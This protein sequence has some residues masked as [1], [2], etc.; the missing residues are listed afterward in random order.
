MF[1][2]PRQRRAFTLIE[3]LV[4][5]TVIAILVALL[6]P[7]VQQ[8]RESSRRASC[9]NNLR[10]LGLAVHMFHD[11]FNQIPPGAISEHKMT[12]AWL[13]LPYIEQSAL[14][15]EWNEGENFYLQNAAVRTTVVQTHL[16]PSR[17]RSSA[18]SVCTSDRQFYYSGLGGVN[19]KIDAAEGDYAG[20]CG[21]RYIGGGMG[22][23]DQEAYS[24]WD[25]MFPQARGWPG[26]PGRPWVI[27]GWKSAVKMRDVVDGLSNTIMLGEIDGKNHPG[28][29]YIRNGDHGFGAFLGTTAPLNLHGFGSDHKGVVHFAFADGRVHPISTN[30]DLTLAGHLATRAGGEVIGEY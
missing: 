22:L 17:P 10:Q 27:K 19:I 21:E 11:T 4:V 8:V 29:L 2:G 30:I 20:V 6:L 24:S 28:R 7:A 16:C 14:F 18:V 15:E 12:W 13:T 23:S 3:L 1:S 26:Y 5:I 25:G 9:K